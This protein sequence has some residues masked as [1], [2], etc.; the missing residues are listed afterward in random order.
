MNK[1]AF[2][3][4]C[5]I[6]K[7]EKMVL[8][9]ENVFQEI[10]YQIFLSEFSGHITQLAIDAIQQG[11]KSL[12][13]AGGDGSVNE[14][15]NGLIAAQT[16]K[17]SIDWNKISECTLGIIP[18]GT[19]NDFVK[20]LDISLNLD[21]LK[22][23]ILQNKTKIIDIGL[24]EFTDKK[25][26]DAHRYFINIT[27]VGMGGIVVAQLEKGS[28]FLSKSNR[29]KLQIAKTF[30]TYKKSEIKITAENYEFQGKVMNVILANGKYFGNGLGIAPEADL[31]DGLLELVVLGDIGIM[32]YLLNLSQVKKCKK[33]DHSQVFYQKT[34][35]IN[36]TSADNRDLPIDMDGEFVGYAPLKIIN[37][38]KRIYFYS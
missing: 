2:L 8:Q 4:N 3:I 28:S 30:L 38:S 35:E 26:Q 16:S 10:P 25:Q 6:P 17:N 14:L 36:I 22:T 15:V 34:K 9:I 33:I 18:M 7:W 20:S 23:L 37:L 27:D 12:I 31:Q 13:I 5:S 24:A 1:I 11:C 21:T 29:Y 32:D 19:G